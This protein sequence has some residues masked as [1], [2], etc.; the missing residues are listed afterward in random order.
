MSA[1]KEISLTSLG[2]IA[3]SGV[4]PRLLLNYCHENGIKPYVVGFTG[5][6]DP[7]TIIGQ[8]YLMTRIGA[9]S[10][11][12]KW[13]HENGVKDLVLIGAIKRPRLF[14]SVP[15]WATLKFFIQVGIRLIKSPVGD[16]DLLNI[17]RELLEK[18]GFKLHGVHEFISDILM[19][20]GVLGLVSPDEQSLTDI[21]TGFEAS[22]ELGASDIGQSVIILNGEVIGREDANGT[23]ALIEKHGQAGAI[24]VKSCKPQQDKDLDLPTIG[25]ETVKS[26]AHKKMAG[27]VGHAKNTLFIEGDKIITTAN[28][29]GLF[30][31]G[32][33]GHE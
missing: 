9:S 3:G 33:T 26:C 6:T 27:I 25:P 7:Q 20:E 18:Q 28:D 10:K 4:L 31:M 30:I 29:N 14:D 21:K 2:I 19:P 12:V 15:D 32:V 11:T 16:S 8:D 24:L 22:Q 17:A 1:T 23:S 13:L 5:Q